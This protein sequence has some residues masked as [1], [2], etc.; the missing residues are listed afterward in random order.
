MANRMPKKGYLVTALGHTGSFEV[1][2]VESQNR[3]VDLRS[4]EKRMCLQKYWREFLGI[5]SSCHRRRIRLGKYD[6]AVADVSGKLWGR[7][8]QGRADAE[9]SWS[10]WMLSGPA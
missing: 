2:S 3:V 1:V 10:G 7:V 5:R 6:G 4:L 8:L 9:Q